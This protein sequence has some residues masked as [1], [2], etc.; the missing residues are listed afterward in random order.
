MF[1][2]ILKF[3]S[4]GSEWMQKRIKIEILWSSLHTFCCVVLCCNV[5]MWLKK[6]KKEVENTA[7]QKCTFISPTASSVLWFTTLN[8]PRLKRKSKSPHEKY[9]SKGSGIEIFHSYI[10]IKYKV[11]CLRWVINQWWASDENEDEEEEEERSLQ[12]SWMLLWPWVCLS[13][14]C[15]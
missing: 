5:A 13:R 12:V 2:N 14:S 7:A 1:R 10:F 11:K 3:S 8:V 6:K 9:R 15:L 4:E